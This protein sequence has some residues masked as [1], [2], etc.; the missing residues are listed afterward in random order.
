MRRRLSTTVAEKIQGKEVNSESKKKT[1]TRG[2]SR[3]RLVT[4]E[5]SRVMTRVV[6]PKRGAW[7]R[8]LGYPEPH[9]INYPP[10]HINT[11]RTAIHD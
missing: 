2:E 4:G 10:P 11:E 3:D 8:G 7:L 1:V 6:G 9:T 5:V